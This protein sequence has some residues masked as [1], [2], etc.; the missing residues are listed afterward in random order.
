MAPSSSA[1]PPSS[2]TPQTSPTAWAAEARSTSSSSPPAPSKPPPCCPR[3]KLP[4][5]APHRP[6]SPNSPRPARPWARVPEAETPTA[7][8]QAKIICCRTVYIAFIG[9]RRVCVPSDCPSR[10]V[11]QQ[12]GTLKCLLHE[13]VPALG[14]PAPLSP[15][16]HLR[17]YTLT[18]QS[19]RAH[20]FPK[21]V[22]PSAARL[23]SCS[24]IF[25]RDR[26]A[27]PR[28]A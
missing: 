21:A 4:C 18:V 23:S 9:L 27:D 17:R 22:R 14:K 2:T 15:E 10:F 19:S 24:N 16:T 3:S 5:P 7:T 6:S 11:P 1:T 12:A 13:A 8:R 26:A 20:R 25:S 28:R